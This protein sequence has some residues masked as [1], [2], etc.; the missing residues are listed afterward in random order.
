[1]EKIQFLAIGDITTDTF[2]RLAEARVT[3]N[4]NDEDCTISMRW[5]DKIPYEEAIEVAGVGNAGNAAVSA[6]RL[7]LR[8]GILTYTGKDPKG[9]EQIAVIKKEGISDAYITQVEGIASNHDFVLSYE[10]ER[11]ILIKHSVF[12]YQIPED[13]VP[14][15]YMYVSSIGDATGKTHANIAA[16]LAKHPETK[17]LFQ[18][19]RELAMD[20]SLVDCLY[21]I[22]EL[23][24][25]NKEESE[26]ILG[27]ASSQEIT[28][29][30]KEMHQL[31]PKTVLITDGR[32]GAYAYDGTH[33]LSLPIYPDPKPPVER[34]GAGDAFASTVASALVLGKPLPEALLW[35]PVNSMNVVQY[36]GAQAGLLTRPALEQILADKPESYRV[37]DLNQP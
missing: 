5:G 28:K 19:G 10:S 1:M 23:C 8:T 30:L 14:P 15:D 18:P 12:P 21:A 7:G 33:M 34:T 17:L 16:W 20:R 11:T 26:R 37:R 35:G 6:A 25:C 4:I 24:V 9:D 31:G 22:A 3:C 29:L 13:L 36:V 32:K 2:I 27:Y